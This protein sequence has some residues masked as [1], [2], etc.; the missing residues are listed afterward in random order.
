MQNNTG[1]QMSVWL[2]QSFESC[3]H[4]TCEAGHVTAFRHARALGSECGDT[5]V[6]VWDA[7]ES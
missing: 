6:V 7:T 5:A 3:R 1:K 2:G 4:D